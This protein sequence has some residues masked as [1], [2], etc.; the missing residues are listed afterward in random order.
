MVTH[1]KI[2]LLSDIHGN[3]TALKAVINDSRTEDVTDYWV[4]GD[5]IMQGYGAS[6]V[7]DKLYSLNPA[8]WVR[9]NWDDLLLSVMKKEDIDI[10]DPTDV[11]IA[12]L[13][14]TLLADL[15]DKNIQDLKKLPLNQ[16]KNVN[17]LNISI[18]HHLPNKNYGRELA[19]VGQQE[20]FDKLFQSEEIDVAIY[21]HIHH[22][23]MR[24]SSS[25]QLIINPGSVG[26]P[27]SSRSKLRREGR[28]QY[29]V[30]EIDTE[31]MIQ[32][33]FK[34][35][36][37]DV[38]DELNYS[39]NSQ[40]PYQALYE[41]QLIHGISRTHDKTFLEKVNDAYHYT[42]EVKKYLNKH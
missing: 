7:F 5:V 36:K 41:E 19:T 30:L 18:G 27:F 35:I 16:I 34:Q 22:Q 14:M 4:L 31:G 8:V 17:G 11:Y 40:L 1:K 9:G 32:V 23:L 33:H 25:D 24:Y 42:E 3:M 29:A 10:N 13:G 37:Y 15:T 21:G 20:A 2:A 39:K 28:A 26:Y 38:Q 6:D 12:K